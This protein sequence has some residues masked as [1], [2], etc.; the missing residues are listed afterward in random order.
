VEYDRTPESGWEFPPTA[1]H[2]NRD[3]HRRLTSPG[4]A[5]L[6]AL[7]PNVRFEISLDTYSHQENTTSMSRDKRR[8]TI[9]AT[10]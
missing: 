6:E 3:L 7:A 8:A 2:A 1:R 9:T 10:S 4:P 5:R